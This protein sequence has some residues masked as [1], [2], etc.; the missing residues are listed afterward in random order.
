MN[1]NIKNSPTPKAH[2]E[3]T[4]SLSSLVINNLINYLKLTLYPRNNTGFINKDKENVD[5]LSERKCWDIPFMDTPPINNFID[6]LT[7]FILEAN[8]KFNFNLTGINSLFYFEYSPYD[9]TPLDW[10]MDLNN[11]YPYSRRKLSFTYLV[12][13]PTEYE[14]GNLKLF[15]DSTEIITLSNIQGKIVF[16]PSFIPHKVTPITKGVRKV[17]VGFL[18]GEPFR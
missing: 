8:S 16:F 12:N 4:P 13:D 17:I 11:E 5:D 3:I 15:F 18:E 7:P 1:F 9:H 14:G 6:E 10:H 2:V